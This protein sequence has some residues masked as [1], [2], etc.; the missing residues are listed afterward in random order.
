MNPSALS[1]IVFSERS[2]YTARCL[3]RDILLHPHLRDPLQAVRSTFT[4]GIIALV[5]IPLAFHASAFT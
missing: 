3:S 5:E 2:T 1:M 4:A